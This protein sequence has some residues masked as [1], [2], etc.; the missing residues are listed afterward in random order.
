MSVSLPSIISALS[1]KPMPPM[2]ARSIANNFASMAAESAAAPEAPAESEAVAVTRG[3]ATPET[4]APRG[5]DQ[6]A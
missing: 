5:L 1:M 6:R 2:L 3:T 4:E